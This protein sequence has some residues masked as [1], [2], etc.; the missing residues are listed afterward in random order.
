MRKRKHLNLNYINLAAG[1][2]INVVTR[3]SCI[4]FTD[5]AIFLF[6]DIDTKRLFRSDKTAIGYLELST[7]VRTGCTELWLL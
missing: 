5:E 6:H 3:V 4:P 1:P 7:F 2:V